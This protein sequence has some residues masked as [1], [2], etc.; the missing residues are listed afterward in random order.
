M[1][2]VEAILVRSENGKLTLEKRDGT[3][4]AVF[5]DKLSKSDQDYVRQHSAAKSAG[6]R[7]RGIV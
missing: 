1:F 7:C 4:I 3:I 2:E 6:A 5:L